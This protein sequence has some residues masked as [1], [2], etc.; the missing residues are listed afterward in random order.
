MTQSLFQ[1]LQQRAMLCKN[2]DN[3]CQKRN[4]LTLIHYVVPP[5]KYEAA[6]QL[7]LHRRQNRL[8]INPETVSLNL[9]FPS[10]ITDNYPPYHAL[11]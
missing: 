9:H 6:Q 5:H 4:T 10:P 1:P 2:L 11:L 7:G 8:K 3:Q